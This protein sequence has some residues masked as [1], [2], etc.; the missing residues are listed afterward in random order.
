MSLGVVLLAL[1]RPLPL[2]LG[3][4]LVFAV[5]GCLLVSGVVTSLVELHGAGRHA[6]IAEANAAACGLGAIAPLAIGFSVSAG[7]T[8]RPGAVVIVLPVMA[9]CLAAFLYRVRIPGGWQPGMRIVGAAMAAATEPDR[10]PRRYWLAWTAIAL[11]GSVEVCLGLWAVDVLTGRDSMAAGA[12]ASAV[13][14]VVVGMFL[15]RIAGGRLALRITPGSLLLAAL[16]LSL[17]GFTVFWVASGPTLAVAGLFLCGLGNSMHYPLGVGLAVTAAGPA[18]ADKAA[19]YT[20]YAI[21]ISFGAAPFALGTAAD[22]IGP[23]RAFGLVPAFLLAAAIVAGRL[24]RLAAVPV[25]AVAAPA[26]SSAP[27]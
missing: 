3:A 6:A 7:W 24:R 9:L 23:H 20:S 27:G 11:T 4:V 13:S 2:T 26:T 19:A 15:G 8:W 21:A 1:F 5:C 14:V 16:V 25:N 17:A 22:S 12:A 10:L 18:L